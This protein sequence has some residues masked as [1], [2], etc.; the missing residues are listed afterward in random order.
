MGRAGSPGPCDVRQ[1]VA[2]TPIAATRRSLGPRPVLGVLRHSPPRR[3]ARLACDVRLFNR[4]DA[5]H[6]ARRPRCV[7]TARS[8]RRTGPSRLARGPAGAS[9]APLHHH[10]RGPSRAAVLGPAREVP[11]G[12]R[13]RPGRSPCR[14]LLVSRS[15]LHRTGW[16]RWPLHLGDRPPI[17]TPSAPSAIRPRPRCD[18]GLAAS[19]VPLSRFAASDDRAIRAA[20][21]LAA[22]RRIAGPWA[23]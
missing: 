21:A 19:P 13:P 14:G 3:L 7:R 17:A 20:Q 6:V 22:Q 18:G 12:P 23:G 16:W 2:E 9:R 8:V 11:P 5:S 15:L 1:A 10:A 4:A